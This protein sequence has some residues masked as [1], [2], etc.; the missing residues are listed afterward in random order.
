MS[1]LNWMPSANE[2]S[3]DLSDAYGEHVAS[4]LQGQGGSDRLP[5]R[6]VA[7]LSLLGPRINR[8]F[9]LWRPP[10]PAYRLLIH[11]GFMNVL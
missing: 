10:D 2:L 1:Q 8:F 9:A 11:V 3:D 5:A 7:G 4:V 6:P